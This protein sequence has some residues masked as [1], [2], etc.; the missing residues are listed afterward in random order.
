MMG[1]ASIK[2]WVMLVVWQRMASASK[3]LGA[4]QSRRRFVSYRQI[5]CR[6]SAGWPFEP[7][8]RMGAFSRDGCCPWTSRMGAQIGSWSPH[9]VV[10]TAIPRGDVR[11]EVYRDIL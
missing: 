4:K 6:G 8:D 1:W 3:I 10:I 7:R 2:I 9:H 5:G 11:L